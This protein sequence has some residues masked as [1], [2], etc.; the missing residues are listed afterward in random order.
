MAYFHRNVTVIDV[1]EDLALLSA[2]LLRQ[3]MSRSRLVTFSEGGDG[4]IHHAK[5]WDKFRLTEN[6]KQ[7]QEVG[8]QR[9]LW[10]LCFFKTAGKNQTL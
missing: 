6:N 9:N 8:S 2:L 1:S 10:L 5:E 3:S 7:S 4:K